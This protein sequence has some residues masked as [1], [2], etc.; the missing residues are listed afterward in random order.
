MKHHADKF[1]QGSGMFLPRKPVV[2][3]RETPL[4]FKQA[5]YCDS[6]RFDCGHRTSSVGVGE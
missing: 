3:V 6:G 1:Q 5:F 2:R 4:Q